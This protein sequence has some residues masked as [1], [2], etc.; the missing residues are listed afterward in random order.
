MAKCAKGTRNAN[1]SKGQK[2]T[3][4]PARE[5]KHAVRI[6]MKSYCPRHSWLR[7]SLLFV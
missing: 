5:E 7:H 4:S 1:F 2:L 6:M 3:H